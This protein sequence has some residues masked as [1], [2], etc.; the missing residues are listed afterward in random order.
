VVESLASGKLRNSALPTDSV[1][2]RDTRHVLSC[3]GSQESLLS[4]GGGGG[5]W[6]STWSLRRW[7]GE[8]LKEMDGRLRSQEAS[9]GPIDE[10][11]RGCRCGRVAPRN[12][13]DSPGRALAGIAQLDQGAWWSLIL[14]RPT[15]PSTARAR[16]T[17][18]PIWSLS[19]SSEGNDCSGR[20]NSTH[21]TSNSSP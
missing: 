10:G 5:P 1:G 9:G 6:D 21:S 8:A 15:Y 18:R 17:S 2:Y 13:D 11:G 19:A 4:R 12:T 3:A 20:R 16:S 7:K 14:A